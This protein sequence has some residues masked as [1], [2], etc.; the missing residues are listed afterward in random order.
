MQRKKLI[1]LMRYE[2]VELLDKDK[3]FKMTRPLTQKFKQQV[4]NDLFLNEGYLFKECKKPV[5]TMYCTCCQKRF[6]IDNRYFEGLLVSEGYTDYSGMP[7]NTKTICPLCHK[8]VTVKDAGRGRSRM[9]EFGYV[10]V[11]QK[12]RDDTV[13]LRTFCLLRDYSCDY[14]NVT[15]KYSEHYRIYFRPGEVRSFKRSVNS[16]GYASTYDYYGNSNNTIDFYEMSAIPKSLS[17]PRGYCGYYAY[18]SGLHNKYTEQWEIDTHIYGIENVEKSS[19]FKYSQFENYINGSTILHSYDYHK[20]LNF[21]CKHP[22][23]CEKLMKEGFEITVFNVIHDGFRNLNNKAKDIKSFFRVKNKNELRA[24]RNNQNSAVKIAKLR[25]FDVDITEKSL[26]WAKDNFLF[27]YAYDDLKEL[28]LKYSVKKIFEYLVNKDVHYSSYCDYISWLKK[29]NFDITTKTAFPR[30]F[31]QKHDELMKYDIRM[32]AL[33]NEKAEKELRDN[34]KQNVLP[35]LNDNFVYSDDNFTVRPFQNKE[36]IIVEGQIQNICVGG[37]NYTKPYMKGE[38]YL[39]CLRKNDELDKPY[40][41]IEVNTNGNLV[42]SR[43]KFNA[44]PPDDVKAFIE[45]WQQV[46]KRNLKK[47]KRIKQREVA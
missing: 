42:Q 40:C 30:Y 17:Y 47:H 8:N 28:I 4:D 19:L 12:L 24:V 21:Y 29:Y 16:Y 44:S 36:E 26:E 27:E 15:T 23:L 34:L 20:Y 46:Y 37:E 10:G 13:L 18:Y 25:K 3:L 7:H 33:A 22:V 35:F 2:V 41:T 31:K 45:K 14:E 1:C 39:F 43:M 5:R 9:V 11:F 32:T 38:T 6:E